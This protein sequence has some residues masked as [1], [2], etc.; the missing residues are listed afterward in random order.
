MESLLKD[1]KMRKVFEDLIPDDLKVIWNNRFLTKAGAS[2]LPE[3]KIELSS[4][5][6]DSEERLKQVCIIIESNSF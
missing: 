1:V 4:K 5:V 2:Y 3:H 6:V